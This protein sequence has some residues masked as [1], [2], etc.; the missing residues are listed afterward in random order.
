M[1][2]LN[3]KV[4]LKLQDHFQGKAPHA[5]SNFESSM[6]FGQKPL[7]PQTFSQHMIETF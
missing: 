2:R 7:D 5:L 6:A 1:V 3:Y 4:L